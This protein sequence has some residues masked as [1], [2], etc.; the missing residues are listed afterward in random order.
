MR[1]L[2]PWEDNASGQIDGIAEEGL[3]VTALLV[4]LAIG[5]AYSWR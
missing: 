1:A 4:V 5:F 3:R 2:G